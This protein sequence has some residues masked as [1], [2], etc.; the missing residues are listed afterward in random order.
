[1]VWH[2]NCYIIFQRKLDIILPFTSKNLTQPSFV[3]RVRDRHV[4]GPALSGVQARFSIN[5]L[6]CSA[7]D[8]I[9]LIIH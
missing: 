9:F 2:T 3:I 6:I 4:P 5:I 7:T 8:N 1:M